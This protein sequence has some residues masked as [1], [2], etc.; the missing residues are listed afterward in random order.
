MTMATGP[1]FA[2]G[3]LGGGSTRRVGGAPA[4]APWG[5]GAP[6]IGLVS[7]NFNTVTG[8]ATAT[9]VGTA[10]VFS[11]ALSTAGAEGEGEGLAAATNGFSTVGAGG[12]DGVGTEDDAAGI[13]ATTVGAAAGVSSLRRLSLSFG[14]ASSA[15]ETAGLVETAVGL[16]ASGAGTAT[17]VSSL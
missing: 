4:C 11:P 16:A 1:I 8:F 7:A 3:G 5:A 13:G 10:V 2:D 9:G 14:F 15:A 17:G 12:D 6:A